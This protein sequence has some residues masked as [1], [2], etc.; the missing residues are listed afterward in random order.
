[1]SIAERL[2]Y[3]LWEFREKSS[4]LDLKLWAIRDKLIIEEREKA[5]QK[6]ELD[7]EVNRDFEKNRGRFTNPAMRR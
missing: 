6:A 3:T 2:G 4:R 7:A 5:E 1:M